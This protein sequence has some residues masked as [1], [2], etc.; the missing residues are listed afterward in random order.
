M[1]LF[2]KIGMIGYDE[3]SRIAS[4]VKD[5]KTKENLLNIYLEVFLQKIPVLS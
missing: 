1:I 4:K 5:S 2:I 3:G